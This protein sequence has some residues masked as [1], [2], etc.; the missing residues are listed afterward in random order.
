MNILEHILAGH[1][2]TDEQGRPVVPRMAR[3]FEPVTVL[4]VDGP[5]IAYPII[6]V[7]ER[8]TA[9]YSQTGALKP[10]PGESDEFVLA[11]C[12]RLPDMVKITQY[13]LVDCGEVLAVTDSEDGE[14]GQNVKLT[15][16][17]Y[18]GPCVAPFP[19]VL[20]MPSPVDVPAENSAHGG[21]VFVS[22]FSRIP[23]YGPHE[24]YWRR[25]GL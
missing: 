9:E 10:R 25:T 8:T 7:G 20:E 22:D 19:A 5:D 17:A 23:A 6:A 12:L 13:V 21:V 24:N 18:P 1:Y 14:G 2:A 15:G 16:Q 4:A 3:D 11:N